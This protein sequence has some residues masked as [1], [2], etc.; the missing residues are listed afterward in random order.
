MP[1]SGGTGH[2][3]TRHAYMH[4][5]R[6]CD[7]VSWG[8]A[9]YRCGQQPAVSVGQRRAGMPDGPT[10][11]CTKPKPKPYFPGHRVPGPSFPPPG[12]RRACRTLCCPPSPKPRLTPKLECT[13]LS[14]DQ[15][16]RDPTVLRVSPGTLR[17]HWGPLWT[18]LAVLLFGN[19]R[20]CR[21]AVHH[22]AR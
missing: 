20:S 5:V 21:P 3:V 12:Y 1:H 11:L 13:F 14:H 2:T 10:A 19:L 22:Q 8:E 6:H 18:R 16:Q 17:P 7:C 4:S 9:Q 15:D